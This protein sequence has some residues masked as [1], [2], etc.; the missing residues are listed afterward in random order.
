MSL[1]DF[2]QMQSGGGMKLFTLLLI[3]ISLAVGV[4]SMASDASALDVDLSDQEITIQRGEQGTAVA[5]TR[6]KVD[7]FNKWNT[8]ASVKMTTANGN[9]VRFSFWLITGS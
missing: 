3:Q 1:I 4:L 8:G 5:I 2:N 7:R 9:S 6:L